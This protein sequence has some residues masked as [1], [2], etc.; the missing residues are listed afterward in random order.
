MNEGRLSLRLLLDT[1]IFLWLAADDKRLSEAA[2]RSIS[3]ASRVLISSASILEI[4]IKFRIGKLKVDPD[5]ALAEIAAN[6]FEELPIRN[7]HAVRVGRLPLHH[8]DPFD[9]LL[10]AQAI[11][12][13]LHL[14]TADAQLKAYSDLVIL[15]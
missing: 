4:A 14:L 10:V 7:D 2:R 8:R 1:H 13:R 6:G 5:D 15:V 11:S 9:R 3:D 12:E